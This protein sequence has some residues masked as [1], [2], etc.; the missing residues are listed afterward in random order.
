MALYWL[1]LRLSMV[2]YKINHIIQDFN[3]EL[4]VTFYEGEEV[5]EDGEVRYKRNRILDTK[6]FTFDWDKDL[7]KIKK[8]LNRELLKYGKPISQ[9]TAV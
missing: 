5:T 2:D 6:V 1:I 9:H 7:E 8:I 4:K 3:T